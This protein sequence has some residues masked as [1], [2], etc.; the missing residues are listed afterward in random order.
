MSRSLTPHDHQTLSERIKAAEAVTR[1]EIYCVVARSSDGYVFPAAFMLAVGV[2]LAS[3]AV[4]VWLDRSWFAVSHLAFA[5]CEAAALLAALL[6]L[7]LVPGLAIR[8]TPRGLRYRRAHDNAM[9]QFL[10][11]NVHLTEKRT[12]ILIF[13]SLAERYATVVADAGI[14]DKVD[15]SEWDAIVGRIVAAAKAGRLTE[16]LADAI[17]R[18]GL[19]LARHFPG[20]VSNPNELDDHVVEI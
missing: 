6:V 8:L 15:Q 9:R 7:R 19:L 14:S 1:G 2:M 5:L 18:S 17:D 16:G 4:A 11:H 10:A 3:V 12:G 13:V 20:G